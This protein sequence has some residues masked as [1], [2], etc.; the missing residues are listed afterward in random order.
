M[1]FYKFSCLHMEKSRFVFSLK[2]A[3][4]HLIICAF[5]AVAAAILV[6]GVWYP[7]PYN[8][9]AGGRDLFIIIIVVDVICGPLIT[10]VF[11]NPKKPTM[12]LRRDFI[13]VGLIQASALIYGIH[14]VWQARPVFL[15]HEIDRFKVITLPAVDKAEFDALPKELRPAWYQGPI[16]VSIKSSLSNEDR[17][18]VLFE[19]LIGGKDYGER[20]EFY[21]PYR[22]LGA[23]EKSK[24]LKIFLEREPWR[25]QDIKRNIDNLN[26]SETNFYYIPVLGRSDWIAVIDSKGNIVS[27]SPGDGF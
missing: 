20:P 22:P 3:I 24:P 16:V 23:L 9:I 15:V 12:E 21:A 7:F 13:L 14:I 6:F 19:S 8:E 26:L 17:K 10:L 2:V 1:A 5:I 27:F 18:K 25:M 4:A 11:S